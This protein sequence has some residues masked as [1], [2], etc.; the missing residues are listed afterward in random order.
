[1]MLA[2]VLL[3]FVAR[4]AGTSVKARDQ[5]DR[6][7][8]SVVS[9][10]QRHFSPFVGQGRGPLS[11]ETLRRQLGIGLADFGRA[12]ATTAS[13]IQ[14]NVWLFGFVAAGYRSKRLTVKDF[15]TGLSTSTKP[16]PFLG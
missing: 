14:P 16:E 2:P 3:E 12:A 4:Q 10:R 15:A 6:L 9:F 1:M 13:P 8:S 11:C 5:L 7:S